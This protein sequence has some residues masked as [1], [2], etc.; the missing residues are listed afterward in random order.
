[1]AIL[2]ILSNGFYRDKDYLKKMS[3]RLSIIF[4]LGY[5]IVIYMLGLFTGFL[6]NPISLKLDNILITIVAPLIILIAQEIIRFIISRSV[7]K[8][9]KPLLV[10]SL[11]IFIYTMVMSYQT[12]ALGNLEGIFIF[13]CAGVLPALARELCASYV[14]YHI[15]Y[16]PC[17]FIKFGYTILP[18]VLPLLPDLGDYLYSVLGIVL[19]FLVYY[20]NSKMV[21]SNDVKPLKLKKVFIDVTVIPLMIFAGIIVI[22]ITGIFKYKMITIAS[23]SMNPIYYRGDA[24]IYEKMDAKD[25]KEGDILVFNNNNRIITHR[26]VNIYNTNGILSFQTK[27]DANNAPDLDITNESKV[28]GKVNWIV[29][30]IGQPSLW[31]IDL[32]GR[33]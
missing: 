12:Y 14:T 33:G 17:V 18:Y 21:H 8:D 31:F 30:Y 7:G 9:I 23:N 4:C 6:R 20:T 11:V 29:K 25:I 28:L 10:Y 26:V 27:G 32:F 3:I 19:P 2:L 5:L 13:V 22:L 16:V 15:S 24:V 1:M